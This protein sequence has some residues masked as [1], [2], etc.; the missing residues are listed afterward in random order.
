MT[1][2]LDALKKNRVSALVF[3]G[4]EAE[5]RAFAM[6]ASQEVDGGGSFIEAKDAA[7]V[8]R[9]LSNPKAIVYVPDVTQVPAATQRAVVRVLREKE[10][11]PKL[12]FG[13]PTSPETASEK[14][15]LTEDLRF[16]LAASTIDVKARAS[17]R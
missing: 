9:A 14:G 7:A 5:R 15:G 6:A 12:V 1:W 2:S 10:E 4:T 11:R 13:L 8:E 3:G 16:W 17:R